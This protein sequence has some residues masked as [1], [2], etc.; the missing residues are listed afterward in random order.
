MASD[1]APERATRD[2]LKLATDSGRACGATE[3]YRDLDN[4]AYAL[5]QVPLLTPR[6]IKI[7]AVGA[8]FSGLALA[9]AVES[10]KLPA[11]DLKIYEKNAGIG[12]TWYENRYP[13]CACDIPAHNYQF[14]WAPNP[15]WES[16]YAN[17]ENIYSYI[18]A[19][20]DQH[21]LRKYIQTSRKVTDAEWNELKQVWEVTV[22][23]TDGRDL[24]ISSSGF[25]D[26]ETETT[27]TE[28]CDILVNASGFFNNWK[29]PDI[30]GREN[31]QGRILH[32]AAWPDDGEKTIDG[33]VVALIG[34]GSSGVQIL[35]A[36]IDRVRKIYVHIR[37]ATWVT[38]G[39]AERFAGPGGSNL[40]FSKEQ[41]EKWAKHPDEYLAYRK[42][43]EQEM[44]AR[45]RMYIANSETQ[46]NARN[47]S[48]SQMTG[49]LTNGGKPE[50]VKLMLP[51]FEVG[52]RRPTPG[53]GYLE[54]LCS[55]KCEVVWGDI[56]SFTPNGLRSASGV[57][58]SV[59]TVICATGFDLSCAPR[60]PVIGRNHVNLQ[61][62]WKEDPQSYL[63][64]TAANMP[65]YFT[66]MGPA[67][68][69]GHG[70]L[71]TSI[72]FVTSYICDLVH[73]LQTQN[74]SSLCPKVDV[75]RA[76]QKQ[77]LAWLDRTVWA[78]NCTSTYKNGSK[79]DPDLK[80]V[81]LANGF[82]IEEDNPS[83][84]ADLT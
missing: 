27:T 21:N 25:T 76:Y 9:Q 23:H 6:P 66:Y 80:F 12:G 53:N 19:V 45:F 60:F 15:H 10:G 82:T 77:A 16:F 7:I 8:G 4:L 20:A 18:E 2:I 38:T 14:S 70:N 47:F 13:G 54:A 33:K 26:G 34:N 56:T 44:N 49:K 39:L 1:F 30:P 57:E 40:S 17:R 78:S 73:K 24:V 43:V 29:W 71:V 41:K 58:S 65:N 52:C 68:P 62:R 79:D 36:I 37:S 55:E 72:E 67:S 75:P 42:E 32:S 28:E 3:A 50:L 59:H 11:V 84:G 46:Q 63:S 51:D 64:V 61:Q 22:K 48:I 31:F 5:S 81:W 74:Y 35:P 83:M 69:L